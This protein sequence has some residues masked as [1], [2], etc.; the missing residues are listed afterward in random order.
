MRKRIVRAAIAAAAGT[1]F[2]LGA[3]EAAQ[4]V[5]YNPSPAPVAPAVHYNP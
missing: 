2:A 4:A 5:H 1:L 3:T